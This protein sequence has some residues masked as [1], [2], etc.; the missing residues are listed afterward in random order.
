MAYF[1]EYAK[2]LL[3]LQKDA[4]KEHPIVIVDAGPAGW[5]RVF[6]AQ[7]V[8][9]PEL[10]SRYLTPEM[11]ARIF[12]QPITR[13]E[14]APL[15]KLS[16]DVFRQ[17]NQPA[18]MMNALTTG[19]EA[20]TK[21]LTKLGLRRRSSDL[22][23]INGLSRWVKNWIT[24][25][26]IGGYASRAGHIIASDAEPFLTGD[27]ERIIGTLVHELGHQYFFNLPKAGKEAFQTWY[28]QNVMRPVKD[29]ILN[30]SP[31]LTNWLNNMAYDEFSSQYKKRSGLGLREIEDTLRKVY[32]DKPMDA[33]ASFQMEVIDRLNQH[34]VMN[35]YL[36]NPTVFRVAMKNSKTK[37][38]EGAKIRVNYDG[39]KITISTEDWLA[40]KEIPNRPSGKADWPKLFDLVNFSEEEGDKDGS[41]GMKRSILHDASQGQTS[42]ALLMT[43]ENWVMDALGKVLAAFQADVGIPFGVMAATETFLKLT[44]DAADKKQV[45]N[46]KAIMDK[47]V[48]VGLEDGR[49]TYAS[50]IPDKQPM[51]PKEFT[52]SVMS[53]PSGQSFRQL[54]KNL[55]VVP[56]AYAASNVD[57]LFAEMLTYAALKSDGLSKSLRTMFKTALQQYL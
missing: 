34:R 6:S 19:P 24:G 1:L 57:E 52:Q 20:A 48:E 51:N 27:M 43:H 36:K 15:L 39:D 10:V 7:Q 44:Q 12:K 13:K 41:V 35:G 54:A 47:V 5:F 18:L 42:K 26:Q 33:E 40:S 30:P 3:D 2:G 45:P 22:V 17:L 53:S 29:N 49:K 4:P 37:K 25:G 55:Q 32:S 50:M 38:P 23:V 11:K 31:K 21:A 9:D 8:A 28:Y 56:S 46:T 14:F 16:P